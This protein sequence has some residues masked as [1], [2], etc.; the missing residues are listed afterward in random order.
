MQSA[1]KTA[2]L[3]PGQRRGLARFPR[4]IRLASPL[5]LLS[6]SSWLSPRD[7]LRARG[8]L[9]SGRTYGAPLPCFDLPRSASFLLICPTFSTLFLFLIPVSFLISYLW[10]HCPVPSDRPPFLF[11]VIALAPLRRSSSELQS[12]APKARSAF[13]VAPGPAEKLKNRRT[14]TACL[15]GARP[16]PELFLFQKPYL[17]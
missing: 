7:R 13:D 16:G 14:T 1:P 15:W 5:L 17:A 6:V 8:F 12:A 11:D 10:N 3:G 4:V 9:I 2:P